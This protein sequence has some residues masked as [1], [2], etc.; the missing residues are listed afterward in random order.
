MTVVAIVGNG[1]E[2]L[3]PEFNPY[4]DKVDYWIGADR[5][6]FVLAQK[7]IPIK[8]AVGDFD[9][10]D[11]REKVI[12]RETADNYEEYQSE[13]DET[14]LEI[15]LLKAFELNPD[16]I[17]LFGVTGGRIDHELANI[18]LLYLIRNKGIK[19]VIID[20]LNY[21][22]LTLPGTYEIMEDNLYSNI[23][24]IPYSE[25]VEGITLTGFYYPLTDK[26]ITWGS[27]R[28]ISNKLSSNSG[29]FSYD[30]G[31]LLLIKSR[32]AIPK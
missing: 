24:F 3:I 6:A 4:I 26:T 2:E 1:P 12:I 27:T 25:K 11:E 17:Y 22:E 29:T 9:S 5:G 14:D 13:K 8:Y 28:C 16:E 10:I 15:A 19:G 21:L 7:E 18:Q 32:D 31:I 23:S 30:K 20:Q